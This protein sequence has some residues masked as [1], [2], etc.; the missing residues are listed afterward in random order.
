MG[1]DEPALRYVDVRAADAL[2]AGARV[3]ALDEVLREAR[4]IEQRAGLACRAVLGRGVLEPVLP[5]ETVLITR[6]DT[7]RRKPVSALPT[8]SFTKAARR[9][10]IPASSLSRRIADLEKE[11]G[12]TLLAR[13]RHDLGEYV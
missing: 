4:L 11:L 2:Q 1:I 5:A 8:G 6:L 3:T 12:A 10:G 13:V 7:D 9:Q